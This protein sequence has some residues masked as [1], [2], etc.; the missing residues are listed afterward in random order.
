[1]QKKDL[2]YLVLLLIVA[3]L[4]ANIISCFINYIH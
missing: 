2:K 4:K 1:M 3:T